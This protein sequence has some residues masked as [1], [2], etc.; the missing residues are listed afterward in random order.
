MKDGEWDTDSLRRL[1][2]ETVL[3]PD[4]RRATFAGVHRGRPSEWTRVVVR[5]V[6]IRSEKVL[7]FSY[8]DGRK[9][10]TK[11]YS[12]SEAVAP[13]DELLAVGFAGIHLSTRIE[14]IDL[15]T[16]K[17]GKVF[18]GRRA[19]EPGEPGNG[20]Q[21]NRTK[22]VPLPEGQANP[23]L[24]AMGILARDGRVRPSFRAKYT[25][26]NEFLKHLVHVLDEAGIRS[27]GR[28]VSILDCGCGSSYLT[29]AVH[30][31]LNEVLKIPARI[32]G[33]DVN[34]EVIRKSVARADHLGAGGMEFLCGRIDSV[35]AKADIVLALHACDT[36]TD[37]ALARAVLGE[38]RLILSVPCCHHEL[39][40]QL[41]A[42]G[43]TEVLRPILRHGILHERA[44]DLFTDAFRA[45]ALRIMGYKT[46]V[47]EFVSPEHTARNLM[48]R[49]VRGV[50]PGDG[51]MVREYL[52]MR[53]FCGVVPYIERL[54]GEPFQRI[55][56][57]Y[58]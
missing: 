41:R 18:V 26:I 21:H 54:L 16:T 11:N 29:L 44:A 15:R 43:T 14:E 25:Q 31:Y 33:V 55:L 13:L 20:L 38:A 45:L 22:E 17:K 28:E 7:Q 50:P 40:Q 57:A 35:D 27:F 37:H 4:L 51:A 49:A 19:V 5:P 30:Y 24:E 58:L 8:F 48:I 56:G 36:A 6:E 2:C 52:E 1:V 32:L 47:V 9:T 42:R 39:N 3:A 12:S 46:D 34:E 53:E 10:L 23:L